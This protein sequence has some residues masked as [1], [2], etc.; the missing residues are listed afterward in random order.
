MYPTLIY[1]FSH[2][3]TY[4]WL[5]CQIFKKRA[6]LDSLSSVCTA[7]V[8]HGA[9]VFT[10]CARISCLKC[11][12]QMSGSPKTTRNLNPYVKAKSFYSSFSSDTQTPPMTQ[13]MDSCWE[14]Q[15]QLGRGGGGDSSLAVALLARGILAHGDWSMMTSAS[16]INLFITSEI[17]G[18]FPLFPDWLGPRAAS[19]WDCLFLL[20]RV[21]TRDKQA[22]DWISLQISVSSIACVPH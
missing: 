6:S 2:W 16:L 11:C 14:P 13:R 21:Q 22:Q 17:L 18:T 9:L 1:Q 19:F 20:T 5:L 15:S 12:A 7:G 8:T 3:R 10:K 4:G